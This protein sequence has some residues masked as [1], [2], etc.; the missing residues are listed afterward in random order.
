[1]EKFRFIVAL[2]LLQ[3]L[4]NKLEEAR[5]FKQSTIDYKSIT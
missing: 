5:A 3:K 1:M 2:Q 4:K